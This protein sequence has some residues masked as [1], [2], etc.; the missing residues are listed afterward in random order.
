MSPRLG[1]EPGLCRG[2]RRMAEGLCHSHR[3]HE[4][5]RAPCLQAAMPSGRWLR[6]RNPGRFPDTCIWVHGPLA[7]WPKG[8]P[9]R[10][11][12]RFCRRPALPLL[13]G[14][15]VACLQRLKGGLG[16]EGGFRGGR[17]QDT[18]PGIIR[19]DS[20]TCRFWF[21]SLFLFSQAGR[22]GIG[23][24]ESW[25]LGRERR[26]CARACVRARGRYVRGGGWAGRG[27]GRCGGPAEP[28]PVLLPSRG[29]HVLL[30]PAP[31]EP[32]PPLL[33]TCV[34]EPNL[35]QGR[36]GKAWEVLDL[37]LGARADGC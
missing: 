23:L 14:G 36:V 5:A 15:Q 9:R 6:A 24:P 4:G 20:W 1:L 3:L 33:H 16:P 37:R 7:P 12:T 30:L 25:A 17:R 35:P 22:H 10:P 28:V 34:K 19:R 29:P 13:P 8:P 21:V 26:A 2:R 11:G 18:G 27:G 31:P 32:V